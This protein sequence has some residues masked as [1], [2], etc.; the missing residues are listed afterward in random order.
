MD[1]KELEKLIREI[2]N[3]LLPNEWGKEFQEKHGIITCPICQQR[4]C[5]YQYD[6]K[7]CVCKNKI[8]HYKSQ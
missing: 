2:V 7:C 1:K 4:T 6:G 3:I 8:S 5:G